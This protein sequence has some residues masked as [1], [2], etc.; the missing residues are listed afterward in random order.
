MNIL[1][2]VY[3]FSCHDTSAAIV[4]DGKLVEPLKEALHAA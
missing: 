2:I 4:C 3:G 1:G